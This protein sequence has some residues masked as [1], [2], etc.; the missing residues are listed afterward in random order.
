MEYIDYKNDYQKIMFTESLKKGLLIKKILLNTLSKTDNILA[1]KTFLK[2]TPFDS[3]IIYNNDMINN[4]REDPEVLNLLLENSDLIKNLKTYAE[5]RLDILQEFEDLNNENDNST[6]KIS[7]SENKYEEYDFNVPNFS[8]NS[9]NEKTQINRIKF[10]VLSTINSLN[11]IKKNLINFPSGDMITY[12]SG[13]KSNFLNIQKLSLTIQKTPEC[14]EETLYLAQKQF[15]A[16]QDVLDLIEKLQNKVISKDN[17]ENQKSKN[18]Y[19]S[20]SENQTKSWELSDEQK[21]KFSIKSNKV[22]DNYNSKNESNLN[23]APKKEDI[24][25]IE[26]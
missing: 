14:D 10:N 15:S 7:D 19:N 20:H 8:S 3:L 24:T 13:E 1:L 12:L 11:T 22:I 9:K 5:N 2:E 26:R 25:D 18:E 17:N 6:T 4:F 16:S 23:N 21:E